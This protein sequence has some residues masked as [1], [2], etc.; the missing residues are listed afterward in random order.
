M[1][2][3]RRLG[4]YAAVTLVGVVVGVGV[5]E[6]TGRLLLEP[7]LARYSDNQALK[8][9]LAKPKDLGIAGLY[10]PHHYYLYGSRPAYRSAD[11]AVRPLQPRELYRTQQYATAVYR[12]ELAARL[13]ALGY[14]VERGRSGQPAFGGQVPSIAREHRF[15][16]TW[17]QDRSQRYCTESA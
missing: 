17:N 16:G 3:T 4:A 10:V 11:G 15:Q 5:L 7:L 14:E 6:V 13:T 9:Q 1:T 2:R 12:S 8:H